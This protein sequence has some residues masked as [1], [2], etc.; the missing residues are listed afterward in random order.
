MAQTTLNQIL[1]QLEALD[2]EELRQLNQTIQKYLANK[3]TTDKQVAFHQ[4]LIDSGLVKQIKYTNYEPIAERGLI[5]VQ[6]K[7]VSE[8]IIEERR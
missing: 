7:P 3:E 5:K 1:D 4:D 8:T 6:G 2:L